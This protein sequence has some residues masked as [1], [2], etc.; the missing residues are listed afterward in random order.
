V[1]DVSSRTTPL[2]N[3]FPCSGLGELGDLGSHDVY[4]GF[5]G[6]HVFV[7]DLWVGTDDLGIKVDIALLYTRFMT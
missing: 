4:T 1:G 7:N 2:S 6:G 5:K 3:G